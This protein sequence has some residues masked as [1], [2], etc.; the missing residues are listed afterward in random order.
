MIEVKIWDRGTKKK[1]DQALDRLES[2]E[3]LG[4]LR[5]DVEMIRGFV[6]ENL[7]WQGKAENLERELEGAKADLRDERRAKKSL[8]RQLFEHKEWAKKSEKATGS[9]GERLAATAESQKQKLGL[10]PA[11]APASTARPRARSRF[12]RTWGS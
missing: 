12:T 3:H 1:L 5:L 6:E 9:K 10:K 4:P 2:L 7:Q 8:E 11:E